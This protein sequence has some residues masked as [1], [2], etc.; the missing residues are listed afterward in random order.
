MNPAFYGGTGPQSS[1]AC[2]EHTWEIR[3]LTH[4]SEPDRNLKEKCPPSQAGS[5]FFFR[6]GGKD[7]VPCP[8]EA[9][10]TSPTIGQHED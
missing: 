6:G 1:R 5:Q 9:N 10:D 3:V 8:W 4:Q 7:C 2:H